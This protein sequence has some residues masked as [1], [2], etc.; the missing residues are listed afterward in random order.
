MPLGLFNKD[1]SKKE[2]LR[3]YCKNCDK[4][5]RSGK[6]TVII[7][8]GHKECRDCR[9]I[10]T[11]KDFFK[12]GWG[13]YGVKGSCKVCYNKRVKPREKTREEKLFWAAKRRASLR[14]RSFSLS[15]SDIIIPTVCPLLEIPIFCGDKRSVDNS[16]TIDRIDNSKGY[17]K[18]NIW[19]I[20]H[21]ANWFKGTHTI[22]EMELFI[23]NLK[24][25]L[26]E[27]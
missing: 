22:E 7:P 17:T 21:K 20:S 1:N 24:N 11:L 3:S 19:V 25:K 4:D 18:E 6:A 5:V 12:S 27:R 26:N 14:G 8:E 23:K 2:N 15:I 9:Q 13:K 16:P 10:K